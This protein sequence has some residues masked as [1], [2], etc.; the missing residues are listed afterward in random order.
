MRRLVSPII[1]KEAPYLAYWSHKRVHNLWK[2]DNLSGLL[3][4]RFVD[5]AP[6]NELTKLYC[7]N[8]PTQIRASSSHR[9]PELIIM[10]NGLDGSLIHRPHQEVSKSYV[11][12]S[13]IPSLIIGPWCHPP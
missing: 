5:W 7:D 4:H 11:E 13:Q 8:W 10:L 12:P 3:G 6:F 9:V 1:I 2:M